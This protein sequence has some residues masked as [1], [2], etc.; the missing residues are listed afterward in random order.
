MKQKNKRMIEVNNSKDLLK[1]LKKA[2]KNSSIY[3]NEKQTLSS[4]VQKTVFDNYYLEEDVRKTLKNY[5]KTIQFLYIEGHIDTASF[6]H[7]IKTLK[8]R[9]GERLMSNHDNDGD[10]E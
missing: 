8:K 9:F 10:K 3:F 6:L 7:L 1:E 4:K 5:K 2:K